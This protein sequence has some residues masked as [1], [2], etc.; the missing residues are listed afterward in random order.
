MGS[1]STEL[2]ALPEVCWEDGDLGIRCDVLRSN[3]ADE[4]GEKLEPALTGGGGGGFF[5]AELA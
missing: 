3:G 5:F 4:D 1:G 2:P